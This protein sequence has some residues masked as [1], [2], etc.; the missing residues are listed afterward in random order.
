MF[1]KGQ[2]VQSPYTGSL[3][4]VLGFSGGVLDLMSSAGYR[5]SWVWGPIAENEPQL[6][7]I[8]NNYQAKQKCSR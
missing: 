3:Y 8:G 6:K 4:V 7:L 5:V 2:V 1:K